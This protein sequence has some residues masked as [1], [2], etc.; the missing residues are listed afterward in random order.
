MLELLLFLTLGLGLFAAPAFLVWRGQQ[1]GWWGRYLLALV[2][3][4]YTGAGWWLGI[5]AYDYFG[6]QGGAKNVHA[7]LAGGAEVIALVGHGLFLSIPFM[8]VA[9]P[10][11]LWFLLDTT[12]K[13][14]GQW[15]RQV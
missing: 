15:N 8:F 11:S 7:C 4:V 14:I 13:H 6:C 9:V 10:L 12:M 2:P 5:V 3:V 1:M